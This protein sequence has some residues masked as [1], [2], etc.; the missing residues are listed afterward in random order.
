MA[1][2]VYL[3]LSGM[4]PPYLAADCQLVSDEGPRQLR[5]ANLRTYVVRRTCSSFATAGPRLWNSLPAHLR[6]TDINFEQFKM[7]VKDIFVRAL[8]ARRIVAIAKLHLLNNLTYL[9]TYYRSVISIY[10]VL[11]SRRVDSRCQALSVT[12]TLSQSSIM[13]FSPAGLGPA[14]CTCYSYRNR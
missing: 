9:L 14:F 10:L 4:A 2:L 7:A 5:S 8:K 11:A 1:T 13:A 6:Q 3:S 12:V